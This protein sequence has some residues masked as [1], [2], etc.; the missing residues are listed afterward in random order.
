M[1]RSRLKHWPSSHR[2]STREFVPAQIF[3]I[4]AG[5]IAMA[6]GLDWFWGLAIGCVVAGSMLLHVGGWS[7]MSWIVR[8]FRYLHRKDVDRSTIVSFHTPSEQSIGLRVDGSSLVAVVEI[9][10]PRDYLTRIGR[11]SFDASHLL[12]TQP[13]PIVSIST[14][15]HSPASTSSVTDTAPRRERLPPKS[16]NVSSDH[17]QPPPPE[18]FGLHYVSTRWRVVQQSNAGAGANRAP[19]AR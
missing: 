10:P 2:I 13:S 3:G 5:G 18:V 12:P 16:T 9:A 8:Y 4:G 6:S 1:D 19:A 15:S 14:T 17:Y 7:V 11:H